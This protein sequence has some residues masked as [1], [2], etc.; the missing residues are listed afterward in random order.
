[1][2]RLGANLDFVFIYMDDILV[3][4]KS[5]HQAVDFLGHL[6]SDRGAEPLSS[7]V[8]AIREF[9]IPADVKAL[10]S[11][12]GLVNFYCQFIPVAT[13][14]LL[15]LTNVL[16]GGGRGKLHWNEETGVAFEAAKKAVCSATLF[17]HPDPQA[18]VSLAVDAQI[19]MWE[20]S[21]SR[22]REA[23]GDR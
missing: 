1:M 19:L 22:P 2:D 4:S 15:P 6:I 10:Q 13:R 20:Q 16:R 5:D 17:S 21:F 18:S 11:F 23:G 3:A 7:H 14:I 9:K 12:L 8:A